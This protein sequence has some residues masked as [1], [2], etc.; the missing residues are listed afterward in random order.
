MVSSKLTMLAMVTDKRMRQWSIAVQGVG[1][2]AGRRL[3]YFGVWPATIVNSRIRP[4]GS[5]HCSVYESGEVKLEDFSI[6]LEY[7]NNGI[8]SKLLAEIEKWAASKGMRHLYGDLSNVDS[9]HFPMLHHLYTNHG[10]TWCLFG[11]GDS[12]LSPGSNIV[13]IVEKTISLKS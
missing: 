2:L 6:D 7:Q 4:R 12:R 10:W 1:K 9:D 5:A 11:K 3:V 13:G 8:G